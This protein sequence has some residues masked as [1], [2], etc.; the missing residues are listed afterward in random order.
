MGRNVWG[1][2][3]FGR[4][5]SLG[6][7]TFAPPV[8]GLYKE[9]ALGRRATQASPPTH[10]RHSRPYDCASLFTS[11]LSGRLRASFT[12]FSLTIHAPF[13]IIKKNENSMKSVDKKLKPF[14][15]DT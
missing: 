1:I 7:G 14:Y 4:Q 5:T 11:K 9:W 15:T 6:E 12:C 10:N 13:R 2:A 3:Q 8:R